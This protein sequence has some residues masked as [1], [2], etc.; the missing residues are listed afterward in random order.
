MTFDSNLTFYN[1]PEDLNKEA[2]II[3]VTD[4]DDACLPLP[5]QKIFKNL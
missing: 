4:L 2:Q 1:L 5:H 3:I